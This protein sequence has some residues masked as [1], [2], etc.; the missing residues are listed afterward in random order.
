MP[1]FKEAPRGVLEPDGLKTA[2]F[3][4][5]LLAQLRP[6]ARPGLQIVLVNAPRPSR[7]IESVL[8]ALDLDN[9]ATDETFWGLHFRFRYTSDD[10]R[11]W[12]AELEDM[13]DQLKER[14]RH[15]QEKGLVTLSVQSESKKW[16]EVIAE[17]NNL[18]SHLTII[19]DPLRLRHR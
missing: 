7:F 13:E 1:L 9:T 15:G 6:F 2:N 8:D 10:T 11:G 3:L 5:E 19:F 14:I 18:P 17:L 12:T 4:A 16:P